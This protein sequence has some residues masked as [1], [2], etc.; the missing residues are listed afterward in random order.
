M[1]LGSRI[2]SD[3]S[4]GY[5]VNKPFDPQELWRVLLQWLMP[6]G[7]RSEL[8][9][10]APEA[11]AAPTEIRQQATQHRGTTLMQDKLRPSGY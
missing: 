1:T 6:K 7:S 3:A 9:C 5:F 11:C 2:G 10:C 8:A 4:N